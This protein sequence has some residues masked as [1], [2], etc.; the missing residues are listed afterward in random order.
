MQIGSAEHKAQFIEE[1]LKESQESVW[2][3]ELHLMRL[4]DELSLT[5]KEL[6]RLRAIVE[7]QGKKK[8]K[9]EDKQIFVLERTIEH[10]KKEIATVE[11]TMQFNQYHLN[12]LLP[13]YAE[14]NKA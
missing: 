7:E 14:A 2:K 1:K 3:N 12:D 8:A 4:H 10:K 9:A 13:R 11:E 6:E 5:Q